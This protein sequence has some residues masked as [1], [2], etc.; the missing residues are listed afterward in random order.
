MPLKKETKP[1][2]LKHINRCANTN[3][4]YFNELMIYF[5]VISTRLGLFYV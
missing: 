4:N 3:I 2:P 1:I 5:D